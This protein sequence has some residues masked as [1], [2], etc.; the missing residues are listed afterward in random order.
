MELGAI[1]DADCVDSRAPAVVSSC[2]SMLNEGMPLGTG[3]RL[4][5]CVRLS[6][7][8]R[9]DRLVSKELSG[10]AVEASVGIG[11]NAL[12]GAG[13]IASAMAMVL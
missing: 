10:R 7:L 8:E 4:R 12:V 11:G 13:G 2:S 3:F 5:D 6:V 1:E 9:L